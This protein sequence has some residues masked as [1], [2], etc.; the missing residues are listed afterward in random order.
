MTR[1]LIVADSGAAMRSITASLQPLRHIEIA[2]YA[3][4]GRR[5][6]DLVRS[7]APDVVIVDEMSRVGLAL[8]RIGE[9]RTAVP[10]VSIVGL[11]ARPDS[12]WI[13]E[14]LRAGAG[15][16]VP[17]QLGSELLGQVLDHAVAQSATH[18][19]PPR[20]RRAA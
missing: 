14:G 1:V 8:A 20:Q 5:V 17:R 10:A 3:A 9:I 7:L 19:L 13:V 11:A 18:P 6:G 2:G 4:G 16:V 15:A 12:S